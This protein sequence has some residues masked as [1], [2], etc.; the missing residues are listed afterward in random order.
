MPSFTL[1]KAHLNNL[2]RPKCKSIFGIHDRIGIRFLFQLRVGLSPL[3]S[4]KLKHN[5][6]DTPSDICL[7]G[8]G[9]EDTR[10][11]LFSCSLY[12]RQ[13]AKLAA[14]TITILTPKNLNHLANSEYLY[15]YG[16][17]SLSDNENRNIL[18]A[19]ITYLNETKRFS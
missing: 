13:R 12:A 2:F 18:K 19:T 3:K 14:T 7:C 6:E 8:I 9:T 16:D 10:H 1:L 11:F 15:L 17:V 4:H 5:F